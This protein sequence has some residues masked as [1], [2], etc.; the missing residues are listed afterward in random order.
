LRRADFILVLE[1]GKLVQT[2]THEELAHRPGI[3]HETALL[4]IMDLDDEPEGKAA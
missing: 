3:Y 1:N 4:Q 2:G